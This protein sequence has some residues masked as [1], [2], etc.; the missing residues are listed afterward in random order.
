[1]CVCV[2]VCVCGRYD[3]YHIMSQQVLTD[4]LN[5]A[6]C[7]AQMQFDTN[8]FVVLT[9]KVIDLVPIRTPVR[10]TTTDNGCVFTQARA[11]SVDLGVVK[12]SIGVPVEGEGRTHHA[13][14][15]VGIVQG[16]VGVVPDLDERFGIVQGNVTGSESRGVFELRGHI[17]G[18]V[19]EER[20][21]CARFLVIVVGGMIRLIAIELGA[22]EA[23]SLWSPT[24]QVVSTSTR[25]G[26]AHTLGGS[27]SGSS[28][29]SGSRR[30]SAAARKKHSTVGER[31]LVHQQQSLDCPTEDGDAKKDGHG[32]VEF[33]VS[34]MGKQFFVRT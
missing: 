34:P 3:T 31:G 12:A 11:G 19:N 29:G 18:R 15:D 10:A 23:L 28:S 4:R 32:V 8:H 26:A 2:C 33:T 25:L 9:H 24:L 13:I 22:L 6:Q 20:E 7:T 1:M 27:G 5:G 30:S 17:V 21:D 16:K 14:V